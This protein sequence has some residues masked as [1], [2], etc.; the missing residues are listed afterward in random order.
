M[1]APRR[2]ILIDGF[3]YGLVGGAGTLIDIL[4][5]NFFILLSITVAGQPE[6]ILAKTLSTIHS[7][8]VTYL[9]HGFWTFRGRG[10]K[11]SSVRTMAKYALVTTMGLVIGVG[12][13]GMSHYL[14]GFQSVLA[15][16][17]ANLVALL[18]S[19]AARFLATRQW[20]FLGRS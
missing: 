16:N 18:L 2:A 12:I 9:G 19:A 14:L 20:V 3:K 8:A 10:G 6:P 1:S 13:V 4:L 17:G 5:F 15:N 7:A 11:R